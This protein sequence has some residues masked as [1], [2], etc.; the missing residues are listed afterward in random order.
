MLKPRRSF[1]CGPC[2]H[3]IV[4][5]DD[6]E[7]VIA[8]CAIG[9]ADEFIKL[10]VGCRPAGAPCPPLMGFPAVPFRLCE[11]WAVHEETWHDGVLTVCGE[12][13][14]GTKAVAEFR[15]QNAPRGSWTALSLREV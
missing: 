4:L 10:A 3:P 5:L 13:P 11:F 12:L 15:R 6:F 2:E 1:F 9:H 8:D 7:E 14:G